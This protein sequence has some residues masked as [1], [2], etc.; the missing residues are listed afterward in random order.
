MASFFPEVSFWIPPPPCPSNHS[1]PLLLPFQEVPPR[2]FNVASRA[3]FLTR[4][5]YT[6]AC[7]ARSIFGVQEDS[8]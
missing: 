2:N 1:I 5:T 4:T 3:L 6:C 8:N 7:V